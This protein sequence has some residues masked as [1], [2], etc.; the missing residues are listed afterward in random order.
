LGRAVRGDNPL[1]AQSRRTNAVT[2]RRR[3]ETCSRR[4]RFFAR[5]VPMKLRRPGTVLIAI[6]GLSLLLRGMAYAW[7][8]HTALP[9]FPEAATAVGHARH[10]EWW[11]RS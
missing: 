3:P 2:K 7:L 11:T 5:F 1:S 10:L 9:W 4:L 8:L 6:V